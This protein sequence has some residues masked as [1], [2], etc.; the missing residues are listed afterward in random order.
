MITAGSLEAHNSF[1]TPDAIRP[2]RETIPA[3]GS[4]PVSLPPHSV[5]VI[6]LRVIGS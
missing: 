1:A 5:S 6:T 3:G 2:R 4:F